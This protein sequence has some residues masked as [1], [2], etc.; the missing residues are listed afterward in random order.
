M[1][2]RNPYSS[3]PYPFWGI[4]LTNIPTST[5]EQQISNS[6][7]QYGDIF[8]IKRISKSSFNIIFKSPKKSN[9]IQS[10]TSEQ[11]KYKITPLQNA[12]LPAK[13]KKESTKIS[14]LKTT[15]KPFNPKTSKL[16][17][18]MTFTPP[19]NI[20]HTTINNN[21][22]KEDEGVFFEAVC[23]SISHGTSEDA[24]LGFIQENIFKNI[25]ECVV[26]DGIMMLPGESIAIF[27]LNNK[28]Q[29]DALTKI[30]QS[31]DNN[32][33]FNGNTFSL[34][35]KTNNDDVNSP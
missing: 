12:Q 6:F 10:I 30:I 9:S 5:T 8:S 32:L 26:K 11:K 31:M 23:K 14:L 19:R 34:K 17:S 24:L 22:K 28:K 15:A 21:N 27:E 33:K 2:T 29:I 20:V 18:S 25:R 35:R 16:T 4:N 1:S 3:S 13:D 7:K